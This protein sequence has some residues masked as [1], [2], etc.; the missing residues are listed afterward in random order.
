MLGGETIIITGPT[1]KEDDDILCIFGQNETECVFLSED[2][3]L[4]VVPASNEDTILDLVVKI[5]RGSA[6][7]T[8][9]T[10]FRYSKLSLFII[11]KFILLNSF[12]N[13]SFTPGA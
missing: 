2:K 7:L 10:K 13:I 9:G 4:C 8:G 12:K 6:V 1:F 11:V 5:I 3:C